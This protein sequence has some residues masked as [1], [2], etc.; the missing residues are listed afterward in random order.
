MKITRKDKEKAD[1]LPRM[2]SIENM[3]AEEGREPIRG[4]THPSISD[5]IAKLATIMEVLD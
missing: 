1:R 4:L 3:E 2:A 5:Q